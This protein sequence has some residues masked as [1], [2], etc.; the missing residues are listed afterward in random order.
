MES[1][2]RLTSGDRPWQRVLFRVMFESGTRAGE[3]STWC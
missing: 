3:S 1:K 2:E